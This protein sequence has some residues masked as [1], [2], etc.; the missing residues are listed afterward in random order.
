[1]CLLA[2]LIKKINSNI[3]M[4]IIYVNFF[5][6]FNQ[7]KIKFMNKISFVILLL[8]TS[9][10]FAQNKNE[11]DSLLILARNS[12][13]DTVKVDC[14]NKLFF[15]E[16]F[17]DVKMSKKYFEAMFLIAKQKKLNYAYAKAFNAKGVYFDM[18]GKLDSA[19]I[20]YNTAIHYSKKAKLL[21]TE[22]SAYNNLGLLDW[23]KGDFYK[24][25][26]N[27]NKSL[28]LFEKIENINY[29]GNT[30]S[31][32]GLIYDEIDEPKK[33][34]FYL[35]KALNIR[36]KANDDYGL[37]VSYV[38]LG[39]LY[40]KQG[41]YHIA[42]QNYEKAI[43]IKKKIND[44]LGIAIAKYNMSTSLMKLNKL[45][46]AL[47]VLNDAEKICKENEAES[48]IVENVYSGLCQVYLGKNDLKKAKE[49][50]SKL[51]VITQKNKD[52]ER[53]SVYYKIESEIALKE[54]N[55]QKAYFCLSSKDSLDKITSGLEIKKAIN[56]YEAKYQS[57]KKEKQLLLA[58]NELIKKE[59]L[60]KK[61]NTQFQ[62][63]ILISL[64]LI[65]IGYLIYRQQKLKNKQQEQ[66]FQLKS[67]IKE[68][69]A[70]NNLHE[71]RLSISR[72][73]H[74]NIGAQLTFVISSVDNLKF[75][76]QINDNKVLNQLTKISDFTKATIIELRDTIWAMNKDE[77]SFEDLRS[78]IFNFIEKAKMAKE[79]I[80][81]EFKID[82]KLAEIKLSSIVGINIYRTIQEAINN[83]I[84]YSKGD[85]II[86]DVKSFHDKIQIEIK[87]NGKGFE[88]ENI[89]FGNGLNN[90]KKRIEEI[91]GTF[92]I[93][94][95][96]NKGTIISILI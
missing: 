23:N 66:E 28:E 94:T 10:C 48:N 26:K 61:K 75:G 80:G 6:N 25:L 44:D 55:F 9:T 38:N 43:V 14:Y 72:D 29:Q 30:L 3:D 92:E 86:V 57:E 58:K 71:Q 49:Y 12:K 77:F 37:S 96:V 20:S 65:T 88:I 5:V 87:D 27:Y 35:K 24:A 95:L 8:I 60:I 85:K 18:I 79:D 67:A 46:E 62:I 64:A 69:E 15:G 83:A 89:D 50:S 21:S 76:N 22:G 82:E 42:I 52:L 93:N 54:K 56:L 45:D 70:Q 90:M 31:N 84:K 59:L 1:M 33:A 4:V 51:Y 17:S 74:D 81:F 11:K 39:K 63:L 19:Y 40:E 2:L 7:C 78:R 73:L 47:A 41:K 53:L 16:V 13:Y 32:I 68:I 36:K 34:E 91:D